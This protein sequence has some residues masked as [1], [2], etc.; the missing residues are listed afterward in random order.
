MAALDDILR[1][2]PDSSWEAR[3]SERAPTT[4]VEHLLEAG[5]VLCF[6]QLTFELTD[7]ERRFLTPSISDGKAKNISLR[8][9]G[10]LRGA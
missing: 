6:P 7:A 10:S 9:D 4:G 2:F 3:T 8:D 1:N 5:H